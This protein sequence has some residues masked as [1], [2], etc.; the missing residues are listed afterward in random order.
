[1]NSAVEQLLRYVDSLRE[2][3]LKYA[4]DKSRHEIIIDIMEKINSEFARP[5]NKR[6]ALNDP[7]K[8]RLLMDI[9]T[10]LFVIVYELLKK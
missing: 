1:M 9:V 6:T 4:D 7:T 5:P 2:E 8:I 3:I 10:K